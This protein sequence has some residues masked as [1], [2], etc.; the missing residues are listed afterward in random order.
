ML[1]LAARKII[2]LKTMKTVDQIKFLGK[3]ALGQG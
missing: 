1:N 2:P 3:K